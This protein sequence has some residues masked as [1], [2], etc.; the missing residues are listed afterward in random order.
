MARYREVSDVVRT[1]SASL[2]NQNYSVRQVKEHAT[3][4]NTLT[5]QARLE[6]LQTIQRRFQPEV[7]AAC[8]DYLVAKEKKTKA[9]VEKARVRYALGT[10]R[11]RVF[12]ASELRSTAFSIPSMRTLH[13]TSSDPPMREEC[14][15]RPTES[16]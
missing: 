2:V 7:D 4:G 5:A 13:S 6:H 8:K 16:A 12:G 10:H 1:L 9:E 15:V 11:S 14:R 3:K